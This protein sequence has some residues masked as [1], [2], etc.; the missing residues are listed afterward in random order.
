MK[1]FYISFIAAIQ[2][3]LLLG[4]GFSADTLVLLADNT[5][6]EIS[7]ICNRTQKKKIRVASYDTASLWQ[8]TSK[9]IQSGRSRSNCYIRFGFEEKQS[10]HGVTCTP[11]QEF[12]SATTRQWVPAYKLKIGDALLCTKNSTKKVAYITLVK[13]S[14]DI[15]TIEVKNTHTFFVT[16]HALLT[17]NMVLP[18]AFNI[19]LSVP[20]GAAGG[21]AGGFFGPI[22]FVAGIAIG[23][24]V[25]ALITITSNSKVPSYTIDAYNPNAFEQYVKQ[26]PQLVAT[27]SEPQ[28]ALRPDYVATQDSVQ[29]PEFLIAGDT[30][31]HHDDTNGILFSTTIVNLPKDNPGC[32]D[33]TPQKPL[34]LITRAEPLPV[35]QNPG[36]SPPREEDKG[37][38]PNGGC[39]IIPDH[40]KDLFNKPLILTEDNANDAVNKILDGIKTNTEPGTET[41]GKSKQ[42]LKKGDFENAKRDFE[43][44]NPSNIRPIPDGF[45]GDLPNGHTI[46]VREKS[47]EG[48]PTLEI[49][50]PVNRKKIKFRYKNN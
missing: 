48:S 1:R 15:Y 47:S 10:H 27:C 17:H 49:L 19:G 26:Q 44:F 29:Q 3:A 22:T 39:G 32:G 33:T 9:T 30:Y 35:F 28:I 8:T 50:N 11:T 18:L 16:D 24:A 13:E 46:N 12:Y 4:H 25:G 37:T 21:S 36:Y 6:Q 20:F 31:I 2:T 45:A 5:W 41:N 34:I 42:Y 7:T 38:L 43:S 40:L 14:L 23:C